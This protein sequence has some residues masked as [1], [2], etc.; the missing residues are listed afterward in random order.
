M[1]GAGGAVDP[2]WHTYQFHKETK[3]LDLLEK[4][5]IGNLKPEDRVSLL[6][7]GDPYAN[8]PERNL[9]FL[10]RSK[11]PYNAEPHLAELVEHFIT[12]VELFYGKFLH[13]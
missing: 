7:Q 13:F 3:V 5:R 11:I 8:E 9:N 4:Y 6:N 2:F 1:M 12:P 10:E